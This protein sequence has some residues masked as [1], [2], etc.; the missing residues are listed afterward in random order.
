MIVGEATPP[1]DPGQAAFD[2]PSS[3]KGTKAWRKELV[4]LDLGAF[5]HEQT[6]FGHLETAHN[7][8]GPAQ[9]L[10][11]PSDQSA[12]VVAVAPEQLDAG[13]ELLDWFQ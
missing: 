5:G 6:T 3:G 13:K 8:H 12:A 2:D 11:E 1:R 10:L 7:G 9:V 4:P